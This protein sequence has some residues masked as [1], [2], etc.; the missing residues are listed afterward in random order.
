MAPDKTELRPDICVIG[1]GA[2]GLAAVSAVAAMGVPVVLVEKAKMGGQNLYGGSVPSKA[3]IAAAGYA[4]AMRD[5]PQFGVRSV[6]SGIDFAAV[7]DHVRRATESVALNNSRERFAGFGVRVIAGTARFTDARTVMVDD[8][9]I[10]ARRFII[11]TGSSSAVPAIAGLTATPHLTSETIFD[12]TEC[13]RHLIIVGAGRTGLELAQAFR[14]LGSEVTVLDAATPLAGYDPECTAIVLDALER[15]GIR[16]R[17]GASITQVRRVLGRV[18][19]VIAASPAG[20]SAREEII[21]GSHLLI[22]TG[23]RANIDELDLDI[24]GIRHG[25]HGITVGNG[26]RTSN[27][28]VYAIGDVTGGPNFAHAASHQAGLVVRHALFRIPV[29]FHRQAVPSVIYTDPELAQVGL[30]EEAARGQAGAIR[31]LRWPYR[32]N[33]RAQTAAATNG[34][35]KVITN[36][37]GDILGATIVGTLAGENIAAWALA[38]GEKLNIRA[39]AGLVA[40]YPSYAEVGKRAA[41]T[42]FMRGLTSARVRRIIGWLRRLG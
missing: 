3:L 16:L 29:R 19:V 27:R 5:G 37:K 6:R 38:L 40:P 32:E 42:Y 2:G 9:S 1:G 18:Q 11:A 31:V 35:I 36:R 17:T 24:A 23:R 26:L 10:H 25:P 4:A 39:F 13:P 12:L 7:R 21:E 30:Q 33:D 22:A 20:A 34:H 41:V 14:R 15:E 8:I 28:R